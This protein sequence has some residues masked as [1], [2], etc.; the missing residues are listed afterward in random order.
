ME[1]RPLTHHSPATRR[2]LN[3]PACLYGRLLTVLSNGS[4]RDQF[5][6]DAHKTQLRTVQEDVSRRDPS[7]ASQYPFLCVFHFAGCDQ[8]FLNKR[9]WKDHI[10]SQHL[11]LDRVFWECTEGDCA[12]S[13]DT[14]EQCMSLQTDS[15]SD[16]DE[17]WLDDAAGW[18][19]TNKHDF[20]IHLLGHHQSTKSHDKKS[21]IIFLPG[22]EVQWLVDRQDSSM[23][24]TCGLPQDLGCPMPQ[25]ASLR[26][27]GATA[28]DQRLNHAA[29]HFLT[30]PQCL[31]VFGGE[32]DA[33]LVQWAAS[34]EVGIHKITLKPRLQPLNCG[35]SVADSGYSS[36]PG[37]PRYLNMSQH[38]NSPPVCSQIPERLSDAFT[39]KLN[40]SA[41]SRPF[42]PH[43]S[44][45]KECSR[46]TS[47]QRTIIPSVPPKTQALATSL[48]GTPDGNPEITVVMQWF[49]GWL[50]QW[51]AP[52]TQERP[53]GH[54]GR[55]STTSQS[56]NSTST[57]TSSYSSST[58]KKKSTPRPRRLPK[59]KRTNEEDDDGN[60]ESSKSQRI[61][62]DPE[63]RMFA[64]PY[65][66]RNP[67]KYGQPRWKSCAHPGYRDIHRVK[68][69]MYRRHSLPEYQCRRCRVDLNTSD[70]LEAH[71]QQQQACT[72]CIGAQDGLSQDQVKRM[73][74]KKGTG[75]NKDEV[76]RWNDVY[77][78]AFP[79]DKDTPSPYLYDTD[80]DKNLREFN[81]CHEYSRF[82]TRELPALV[83]RRLSTVGCP[84][85][86][87]IKDDIEQFV[88]GLVPQLQG[89]FL[90][91]MGF[92]VG[93]NSRQLN[94]ASTTNDGASFVDSTAI[95]R[96]SEDSATTVQQ[97]SDS[98]YPTTTLPKGSTSQ[99]AISMFPT[100]DGSKEL[101]MMPR[102]GYDIENWTISQAGNFSGQDMMLPT[103]QMMPPYFAPTNQ[104]WQTIYS[105]L[106]YDPNLPPGYATS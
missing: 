61:D 30:S 29:E 71:L 75:K 70:A 32:R 37:M 5:Y 106:G 41:D 9:D 66:K 102:V 25:C 48:M 8:K 16:Q 59:R 47:P 21:D 51:L 85:P 20:R 31:D 49:H 94:V 33:E 99:G 80:Q 6:V 60:E 39:R 88:K 73:R 11:K 57:S 87:T 13:R 67:R 35:K 91:E 77:A 26:F 76:E 83:G 82:L 96:T 95:R 62:G 24:M 79:H 104:D 92:V 27:T 36:M 84:L 23:R 81:V 65:F 69:H 17:L 10:I 90:Q 22:T 18:H 68:E 38:S 72:P 100:N 44:L 54:G 2:Y 3:E 28:W 103:S 89:S 7:Q 58:Q 55:Q 64:C 34:S 45:S 53:D 98:D 46:N 40:I 78:I 105:Q 74:S 4:E 1:H 56:Q 12:F 19:F 50:R 14:L 101:A 43:I 86:E 52:L 15:S 42:P 63:I 93:D 97:D